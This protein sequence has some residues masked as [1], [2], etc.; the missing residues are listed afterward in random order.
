MRTF[1]RIE[2]LDMDGGGIPKCGYMATVNTLL[3]LKLGIEPNHTAEELQK[4]LND[5]MDNKDVKT[6]WTCMMLLS[7]IPIP[8]VYKE[9]QNNL[10]CLYS[11]EEYQEAADALNMLRDIMFE[12]MPQLAFRYKKFKLK[13]SEIIYEDT[14]QVVITKEVYEKHLD[15]SKYFVL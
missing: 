15:D 11:K 8:E 10:Y 14:Y 1:Y 5:N 4:A 9:N 3:C 12:L 6:L 13:D 2:T 7:D